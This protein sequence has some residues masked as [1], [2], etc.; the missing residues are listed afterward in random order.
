VAK[1]SR[2]SEHD[3]TPSPTP[4]P[5]R[6]RG[7]G[8]RQHRQRTECFVVVHIVVQDDAIEHVDLAH[9][10]AQELTQKERTGRLCG[11]GSLSATRVCT[12]CAPEVG[13]LNKQEQRVAILGPLQQSVQ[14]IPVASSTPISS[15][16]KKSSRLTASTSKARADSTRC[17]PRICLLAWHASWPLCPALSR[18]AQ[19]E[20][21]RGMSLYQHWNYWS[22]ACIR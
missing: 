7:P 19:E 22:C 15:S 20:D 14:P 18:H 2:Q 3:S 8:R 17:C 21:A 13:Y 1:S 11:T 16:N 6:R 4:D 9:G 5:R 12:V 10:V